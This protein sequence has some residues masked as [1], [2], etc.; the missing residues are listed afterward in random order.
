MAKLFGFLAVTIC[1]VSCCWIPDASAATRS[2]R[3]GSRNIGKLLATLPDPAAM[4]GDGFGSEVA[5]SGNTAVVGSPTGRSGGGTA[6]IYVRSSSGWDSSPLVTLYNPTGRKYFGFSVA[7]S[8]DYVM[9][10][11]PFA[12]PASGAKPGTGAVYIFQKGP[13]LWK[14]E[15]VKILTEPG[16]PSNAEFGDKIAMFDGTA[17]VSGTEGNDNAVYV[18]KLGPEGWSSEPIATF[19]DPAPMFN[20]GFGYS[21]SISSDWAAVGASGANS[22]AGAVYIYGKKGNRWAVKPEE[23]LND[24]AANNDDYFGDSVSLNHR[25]LLIGARGKNSLSGGEA[26]IY[27]MGPSGWPATPSVSILDPVSGSN[28]FGSSVGLSGG[29][30]VVGA[31]GTGADTG[32]AYIY[33]LEPSGWSTSPAASLPISGTFAGTVAASGK[34]GIIGSPGTGNTYVYRL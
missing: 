12:G 2:A 3:P 27:E 4:N 24:P 21:L 34:V 18:Y 5:I 23:Q 20:D 22:Y 19:V 17:L 8:A 28:F 25:T 26:Y 31:S 7:V 29:A 32:A 1:I 10:G 16:A 14:P 6:H 15:A 9:V 33:A 30:A 11:N 13:H